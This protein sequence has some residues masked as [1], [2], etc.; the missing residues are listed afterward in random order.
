MAFDLFTLKQCLNEKKLVKY[1]MLKHF[2]LFAISS[3]NSEIFSKFDLL[4]K[5]KY[6][7]EFKIQRLKQDY[8]IEHYNQ[9]P[10]IILNN[11][12]TWKEANFYFFSMIKNVVDMSE[13][14]SP[15]SLIQHA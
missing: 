10:V 3:Y 14:P 2:E 11:G 7:R 6:D 8:Q 13:L 12:E 4:D 9:F 5:N 15:Q 1:R